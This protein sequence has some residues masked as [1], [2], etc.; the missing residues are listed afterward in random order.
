MVFIPT[1][2][3][4]AAQLPATPTITPVSTAGQDKVILYPVPYNPVKQD[5]SMLVSL[6]ESVAGM[7]INIYTVSL[8]LI[9]RLELPAAQAGDT[10]IV[11]DRNNF[12]NFS[13]GAYYYSVS[14]KKE[15]ENLSLAHGVLLII[16][17]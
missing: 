5:L 4:T 17:Q 2:T 10:T 8:R 11:L 12:I 9:K 14:A 16:K 6:K 13:N 1:M 15:A 7:T 3:A